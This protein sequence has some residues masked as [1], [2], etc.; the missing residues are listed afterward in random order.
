MAAVQA[1]ADAAELLASTR[2][3]PDHRAR[4]HRAERLAGR[5]VGRWLDR[6]TAGRVIGDGG[7]YFHIVDMATQPDHQRRR[8]VTVD[9]AATRPLLAL[10]THTFASRLDA[11]P[12]PPRPPVHPVHL[13]LQGVAAIGVRSRARFA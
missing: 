12:A 13:V 6:D 3:L 1:L 10:R 11:H 8:A 4:P 5:P 9:R 7:W 2:A